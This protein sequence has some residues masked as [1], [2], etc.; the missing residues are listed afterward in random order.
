MSRFIPTGP[1][2]P[3]P[4]SE[5]EV[6][7][8]VETPLWLA[9]RLRASEDEARAIYGAELTLIQLLAV[10]AAMAVVAI[11]AAGEDFPPYGRED[12]E[13]ANLAARAAWLIDALSAPAIARI[14]REAVK[15]SELD[16]DAAGN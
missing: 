4:G 9:E 2:A 6:V 1:F 11:P 8:Y 7:L 10:Q 14:V 15:R 16:A 12:A 3:I 13:R 5:L